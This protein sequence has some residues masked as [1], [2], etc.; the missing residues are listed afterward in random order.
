MVDCTACTCRTTS[1]T[2]PRPPSVHSMLSK[3]TTPPHSACTHSTRFYSLCPS[4]MHYVHASCFSMPM[5]QCG[6][7]GHRISR[8][9]VTEIEVYHGIWQDCELSVKFL[10]YAEI[11]SKNDVRMIIYII[12]YLDSAGVVQTRWGSPIAI[13]HHSTLTRSVAAY[14]SPYSSLWV[15]EGLMYRVTAF[16]L[17]EYPLRILLPACAN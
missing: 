11:E 14:S 5:M 8:L 12:I 1:L 7:K 17:L 2:L 9:C 10:T 6:I 16:E 3:V 4:P 13:A 15:P